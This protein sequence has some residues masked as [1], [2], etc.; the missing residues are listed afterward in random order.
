[1]V[2]NKAQH[3]V[4]VSYLQAWTDPNRPAHHE[5]FVHLF[6]RQGRDHKRRAPANILSMPDVYTIFADGNRD[7]S[8]EHHFGRQE[9]EFVRVRK[10]IEQRAAVDMKDAAALYAFVAGMLARP[11]HK[12]NHMSQQWASIVEQAR[13]IKIDPKV[14]PIPRLKSDRH[15]GMTLDEAQRLADDP[16]GTWF[17]HSLNAHF[18]AL[19]NFFGC[20]VLVNGSP[21]PFL[22]SDNPAV[23]YFANDDDANDPRR[24]FWPKGLGAVDCEITIPISPTHALKFAHMSPGVHEW[25]ALDWEAVFEFNFLTITRARQ[26]IIS[27]RED[28]F[29][30]RTILDRVAEVERDGPSRPA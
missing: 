9:K 15:P 7:L 14:R 4:P 23:I 5:P 17:P 11:P 10:L 24:K 12:I 30:V 8:I 2:S 26:T 27:D 3:V 21:H 19:T 28:L 22:T 29:F 20:D 6:D 16:M 18:L 13:T 25:K 1:M